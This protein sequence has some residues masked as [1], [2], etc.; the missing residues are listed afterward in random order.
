MGCGRRDLPELK[1]HEIIRLDINKDVKPDIVHDLNKHPLPFKD[2]EFDQ[3]HA[4][5]VLEHLG[6]QGDYKFFF[7]EFNE[8]WRILKPDG[9]FIASTPTENSKWSFGDPGHTRVFSMNYL[10]YLFIDNYQ[11][12]GITQMTDYRYLYKGN[13]SVDSI[14]YDPGNEAYIFIL[15]KIDV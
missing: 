8:Y 5:D 15:R 1:E 6:K 13:F 9:L 11:Q 7:S 2:K 10:T 12:C 4:Y 3:I 14:I